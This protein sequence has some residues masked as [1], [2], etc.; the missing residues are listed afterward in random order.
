V[1]RGTGPRRGQGHGAAGRRSWERTVG[2]A[3]RK[4]IGSASAEANDS[5]SLARLAAR[6]ASSKQ[7]TE[8][9]ILDVREL[10]AI[11]DYFVIVSAS[12]DRQVA[13]IGE[14]VVRALKEAGLRPARR[15]GD[16]GA[17]WLLLD[18]VD[19]VVHVFHEE[20][21]EFYRLERLWHDAPLVEWQE[22]AEV[23]S[24]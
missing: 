15:E 6:A 8:I 20:E 10:I 14:E 19:L 9:L 3:E 7:G 18:F 12:S 23:T 4:R 16:A 5:R 21:R 11:T 1:Y 2:L 24:G 13:T 17:R 22:P